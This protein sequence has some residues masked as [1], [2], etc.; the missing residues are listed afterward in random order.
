M[1]REIERKFLIRYLPHGFNTLPHFDIEQG[2]LAVGD[3]V[4][5][6]RVYSAIGYLTIK[7]NPSGIG[8]DEYE[9]EIPVQ[10]AKKL[11]E[12]CTHGKV[13][14]TRYILDGWEIDVFKDI[15][16]ILAEY[17]LKSEDEEIV[18]P[19]WVGQEVTGNPKYLNVNIA[20]GL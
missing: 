15:N 16:L 20:K 2:Y 8:V 14:K 11:I 13:R 3:M 9:Y 19:D 6:A 18:I 1:N 10:D 5:R 12:S 17:E 4:I 7:T